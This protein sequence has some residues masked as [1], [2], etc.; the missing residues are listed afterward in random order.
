MEKAELRIGNWVS[1]GSKNFQVPT[2]SFIDENL[3]FLKPI[4]VTLKILK[5]SHFVR[6]GGAD[7]PMATEN[8]F[9]GWTEGQI[10][11]RFHMGVSVFRPT[12]RWTPR[13]IEEH[14]EEMHFIAT[15]EHV[16]QLQNIYYDLFKTEIDLIIHS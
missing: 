6:Y 10:I 14:Q 12:N 16:H 15:I 9:N 8:I 4:P 1:D 5:Q 13:G 2:G 3:I 11:I 7:L